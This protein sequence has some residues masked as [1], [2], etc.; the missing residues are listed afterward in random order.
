MSDKENKKTSQELADEAL[1]AVSGGLY[2]SDEEVTCTKCHKPI[3]KL[4]AT[5]INDLYYCSTC[6]NDPTG[7]KSAAI[8]Y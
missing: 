3:K 6:A 5:V 2:G 7:A 8:E 4:Q 1:D